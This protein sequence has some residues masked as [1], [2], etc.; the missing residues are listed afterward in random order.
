MVQPAHK[1]YLSRHGKLV[2]NQFETRPGGFT[3]IFWSFEAS[4]RDKPAANCRVC[5]RMAAAQ[6]V[7][8]KRR[9]ATDTV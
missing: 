7:L 1:L 2:R 3:V 5:R 9:H 6:L 4:L 8:Y